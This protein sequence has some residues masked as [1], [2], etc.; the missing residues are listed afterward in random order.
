MIVFHRDG[1]TTWRGA[2]IGK[3]ERIG[4]YWQFTPQVQ[5]VPTTGSRNKRDVADYLRR[6]MVGV[7][8]KHTEN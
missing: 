1:S 8:S 6:C 3:I 2:H 7:E 4:K 5:H